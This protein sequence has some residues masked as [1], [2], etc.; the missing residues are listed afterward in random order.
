MRDVAR[1]LQMLALVFTH[2]HQFGVV[3]QHVGGLQHR[4]GEQT[5]R[6]RVTALT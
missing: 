1:Q 3:G 2:R 4:I 5:D 6:G